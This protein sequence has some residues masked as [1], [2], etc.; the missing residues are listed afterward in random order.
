MT[1]EEMI[2]GLRNAVSRGESLENAKLS[3]VNAG[4]I[5]SDVEEAA[6]EINTG[7]IGSMPQSDPVFSENSGIS[8]PIKKKRS[9]KFWALIIVLILLLGMLGAFI[10]F[11]PQIL[12]AVT[13]KVIKAFK[14]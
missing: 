13:G 5:Y 12:S 9:W 14:F 7:V 4:Y 8:A 11:G 3:L 1:K 6:K 10:F 2:A